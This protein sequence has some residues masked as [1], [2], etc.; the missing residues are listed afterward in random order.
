MK[1][2]IAIVLA[3]LVVVASISATTFNYDEDTKYLEIETV[4]E[5]RAA[6]ESESEFTWAVYEMWCYQFGV[7]PKYELYEKLCE[8]PQC[9]GDLD[10]SEIEALL[11]GETE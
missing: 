6:P 8:K 3:S 4:D 2:L 9:Y 1:K 10:G 11:K 5:L 7:E